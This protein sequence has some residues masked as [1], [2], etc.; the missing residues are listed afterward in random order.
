MDV[1]YLKPSPAR[2]AELYLPSL[3]MAMLAIAAVRR[4]S[5]RSS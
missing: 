2:V 4:T 3:A 1:G 5:F